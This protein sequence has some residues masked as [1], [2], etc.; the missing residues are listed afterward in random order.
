MRGVVEKPF[1]VGARLGYTAVK[2]S[3]TTVIVKRLTAIL[4]T[5]L[6]PTN[7]IKAV[8]RYAI[9]IPTYSFKLIKWSDTDLEI[10]NRTI[11]VGKADYGSAITCFPL[12]TSATRC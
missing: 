2:E 11:R 7:K 4:E 8:D 3:L 12:F 6:S 1:I 5:S 9:P 10:L